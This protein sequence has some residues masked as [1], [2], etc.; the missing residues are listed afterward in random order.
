MPVYKDDKTGKWYFST[1][2]K[3]VYGNNKRKMKR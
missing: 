3:D 1:R 2:Y